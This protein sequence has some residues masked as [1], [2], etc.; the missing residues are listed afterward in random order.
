MAERQTTRRRALLKR[1][2]LLFGSA[3][4]LGLAGKAGMDAGTDPPKGALTMKV[5]GAN[6]QLTYPERRR[7]V[8]PQPG[9]R[10]AVFGQLLNGP[11]GE[12]LG[13]F[14]ASSFEFGTPFGNSEVSA[15]AMETHQFNFLDGSIIGMGTL[16]DHHG[17]QSVHAII[18][19]T[20]RYAGATGT[21]TARQR[22]VE[23]G[24]DGTADF[25]FSV[26][27]RSA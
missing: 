15:G 1:G 19:G 27:L 11:D 13:E 5:H 4:G 26:I 22:P 10:S 24:G 12:K 16:S 20:G 23:M 7:G 8:V 14:Y 9:E 3:I 18:G 17:S 25:E 2:S 6:W 21:Y